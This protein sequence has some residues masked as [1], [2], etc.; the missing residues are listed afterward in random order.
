MKKCTVCGKYISLENF[1]KNRKSK[2]GKQ[3]KCKTCTKYYGMWWRQTHTSIIKKRHQTKRH[4]RLRVLSNRRY[5]VKYPE[6]LRAVKAVELAINR[7]DLEKK[8]C[9]VCGSG[10]KIQAHHPDYSKP[11]DVVW[12]CDLHHKQAHQT[13][14]IS[15]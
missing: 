4:K 6:K 13:K 7:G 10:L 9:S 15:I 1:Y 14:H 11:L 12:L 2:D 8:P 5:N 3:S